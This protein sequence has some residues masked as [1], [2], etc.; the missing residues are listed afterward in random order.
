MPT[1]P[2]ITTPLK[3]MNSADIINVTAKEVGGLLGNLPRA[4]K[5]GDIM[6]NGEPATAADSIAS[7]RSI[8]NILMN[9][10]PMQNAFLNALVNR[11]GRVIITSR[12]YENPWSGFKKGVLEYGETI[13]EIF[14]G[15]ANPNQYNPDKAESE[16]FKRRMP[17]VK[18]T[19][20]SMNYQKF[21]PTTV[22]NDQL[23]QAFLSW[24][25]VTDL[26]GRII[27]QVYT[28]ANY[29]EFLVMK[30]LI[31]KVALEG[32]IYSVNIPAVTADNARTVTSTMVSYAKKLSF[33]S[34][35]YNMAGVK[36]Y[37]NPAFLHMILT[38]D[39]S[40]IFDVEVL[41]L[42]FNIDKA[43][44]IG[45]QIDVDGFGIIDEKRLALIFKDDKYT[46]YTPF[47]DEEKTALSDIQALMVDISWFMIFD[48][49]YNMTEIYNPEGLYWNYFY[50][51]WKTF[52][53]S[54]FSNAVVFTT[55]IP[56][57]ASI[58][59]SPDTATIKKGS[60]SRFVASVVSN[61]FA[62]KTVTWELSGTTPLLSTVSTEG[63]VTVSPDETNTSLTLTATST[64]DDT[65]ADTAT[66]TVTA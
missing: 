65:K 30:Y 6:A 39:I 31:A 5:E 20:H 15:L 32:N 63:L 29:D 19:F 23:R 4:L 12:L 37:T 9:F 11:I 52:S 46:Q 21:Y 24:Q 54:P 27:E 1:M 10:V 55:Q 28:G 57:I 13:E 45:R 34:S 58:T 48:N 3:D 40:S 35:T 17:D 8:G 36:T 41:A 60:T 50:H 62:P 2:K 53:I 66:I 38:T 26:I 22:S 16:V 51:V 64:F 25:G 14:V 47:T 42:S 61:G 18:A 49:F 59:V 7:L 43:E 33:M 44:L 56:S